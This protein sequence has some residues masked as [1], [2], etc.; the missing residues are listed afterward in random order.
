MINRYQN[1]YISDRTDNNASTNLA[2]L[3]ARLDAIQTAQ[4]LGFQE[5][6]IPFLILHGLLRPLGKPMQNSRKYFA[7]V[8]IL[9]FTYDLHW[10]GKATQIV[11]ECW[12]KKNASRIKCEK[13]SEVARAV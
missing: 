12:K 9:E 1:K 13:S 8:E 10:L 7:K 11:S 3:P 2:G 6:D 5:H 4:V